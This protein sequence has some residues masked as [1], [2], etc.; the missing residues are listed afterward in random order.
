MCLGDRVFRSGSSL[1]WIGREKEK[2]VLGL[3]EEHIHK[4]L[5]TVEEMKNTIYFLCTSDRRKM[6]RA[7]ERTSRSE[8]KADEV[9]ARILEELSKGIFHPIN[10]DE[11]VRLVLT[12]DDIAEN[13][14]AAARKAALIPMGEIK[15]ICE[16]KHLSKDLR[17]LSDNLIEITKS[18][19]DAFSSLLRDPRK[20][21]KLANKVEKIEEDIDNFRAET[22]LPEVIEWCDKSKKPGTS[23]LL[24]EMADNMEEVADRAEDVADVV[25]GI[26]ISSL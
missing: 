9:K 20:T 1:V 14:K 24:K 25:R 18:V 2:E 16:D 13:A 6:I 19:S 26:A 15:R 10:R 21:I 23:L 4:I 7:S 17:I 3:C 12:A 11:I 8:R 5:K 22:L